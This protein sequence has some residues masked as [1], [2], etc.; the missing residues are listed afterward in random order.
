MLGA[1][2]SDSGFDTV[3]AIIGVFVVLLNEIGYSRR[4]KQGGVPPRV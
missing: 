2:Y 3:K 4:L 1:E